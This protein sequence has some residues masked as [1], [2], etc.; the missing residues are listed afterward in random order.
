MQRDL[1]TYLADSV[2]L[3]VYQVMCLSSERSLWVL[4][5]S[6]RPRPWRRLWQILP[7]E[8]TW[9][10]CSLMC[11]LACKPMHWI[12]RSW[13]ICTWWTTQR[14]SRIWRS[15]LS[16]R[17][18]AY[19]GSLPPLPRFLLFVSTC[20]FFLPLLLFSLY[21]L[22]FFLFFLLFFFCSFFSFLFLF[23]FFFFFF[24]SIFFLLQTFLPC[25]TL[26]TPTLWSVG[27]P[28][29]PC[30]TLRLTKSLRPCPCPSGNASRFIVFF[31]SHKKTR[32]WHPFSNPRQDQDPYVRKTAAL[33]V[34]KFYKHD[35]ATAENE[36]FLDMLKNLLQDTNTTVV[37]NA[38][39]TLIE[40]D[41]DKAGGVGIAFDF[42]TIMKFLT[43]L[44]ESSEYELDSTRNLSL[45]TN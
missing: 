1:A 18:F 6:A 22:L 12:S 3:L 37:A 32:L 8:M 41:Q 30:L 25:R 20:F 24:F 27:W 43:A 36:G 4:T 28:L 26:R 21:L 23:F 16:T 44:N 34:G 33:C 19:E 2:L 38:L 45:M 31:S 17:S 39:A 40:I 7:W 13:C 5:G 11:W 14:Q 10:H 42:S 29:E 35:P 15:W 9:A